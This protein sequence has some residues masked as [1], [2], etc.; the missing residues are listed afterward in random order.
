ML[1]IDLGEAAPGDD[2]VESRSAQSNGR[3]RRVTLTG[4]PRLAAPL[5]AVV[6]RPRRW[7][8]S[9]TTSTASSGGLRSPS[10]HLAGAPCALSLGGYPC[11]AAATG[12]IRWTTTGERRRLEVARLGTEAERRRCL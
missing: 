7:K 6:G 1:G 5:T 10:A 2:S 3:A 4:A 12:A 8:L 9:T 11:R